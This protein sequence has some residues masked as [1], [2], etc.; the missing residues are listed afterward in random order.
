LQVGTGIVMAMHYVPSPGEAHASVS[1]FIGEV[2]GGRFVRSVHYW[3]A[4]A[5]I[6]VLVLHLLRVYLHAA[7]KPPR[8]LTWMAGLL[9]FTLVLGFAFTGDLLRWDQKGYWMTVIGVHIAGSTPLIGPW[10]A[11]LLMGGDHIGALTLPRF[12]AL[13]ILVLPGVACALLGLHLYL[14]WRKGPAPPGRAVGESGTPASTFHPHQLLRDS[15][16]MIAAFAIIAV[17]ALWRTAPLEVIADPTSTAYTPRPPWFLL[18]IFFL[19]QYAHGFWQPFVSVILPGL[20][21]GFLML[22]PFLDRN[23][24]RR[25]R[26]RPVAAIAAPVILTGIVGLTYLGSRVE[27][28][29][30]VDAA[31]P[32]VSAQAAEAARALMKANG[33][34]FC[35]TMNGG[36]SPVGP[37]LQAVGLRRSLAYIK[38]HIRNAPK[39]TPGTKMPLFSGLTDAQIDTIANYLLSLRTQAGK[40]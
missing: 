22:L 29:D 34:V 6:I 40:P 39:D 9:L 31:A 33:C 32:P 18:S 19:L 16:M 36:P 25:L 5:L 27:Y 17:L 3:S 28:P 37:D 21:I 4:N 7:Y 12:Y 11:T 1:Y 38:G 20:F 15:T 13:H 35:H 23:P 26:K 14:V 10:L 30:A 8:E 2:L 24:E